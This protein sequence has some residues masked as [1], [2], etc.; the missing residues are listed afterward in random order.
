MNYRLRNLATVALIGA[1][2]LASSVQGMKH[3]ADILPQ[4]IK[5][6]IASLSLSSSLHY[7]FELLEKRMIFPHGLA[8]HKGGLTL[9]AE[10]YD[11]TAPRLWSTLKVQQLHLPL[12]GHTEPLRAL[13]LSSDGAIALTGA[14]DCTARLWNVETGDLL[15]EPLIHTDIVTR[16]ALSPDGTTAVTGLNDGTICFWNIKTGE[17]VKKIKAHTTIICLIVISPDG[18]TIFTSSID[19]SGK[20]WNTTTGD[21]LELKGDGDASQ[22]PMAVGAFNSDGKTL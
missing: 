20:L 17:L 13:A 1:A 9:T 18:E 11:D 12:T 16:I 8:C 6:Y 19:K 2:L 22:T 15:R 10:L 7:N 5:H 21:Y 4:E 14:Q 3:S